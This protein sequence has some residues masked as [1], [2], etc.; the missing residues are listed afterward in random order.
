MTRFTGL[1][2]KRAGGFAGVTGVLVLAGAMLASQ[3]VAAAGNTNFEG[4]L[5]ASPPAGYTSSPGS[6]DL[7][8]GPVTVDF[9][10]TAK[11]L[12]GEA[13]TFALN[14]SADHILTYN[15]VNVA[16]GQ[17]GQ[18]GIA[19]GGPAGTTQALMPGSQAFNQSWGADATE[20]LS[21]TYSFDT[22]GYYQ[23][24]VWAPWKDGDNS[25][26]R[27]T[28]ASGFIRVL[29]C[30]TSSTPDPT[31]SPTPTGGEGAAT[32]TPAPTDGV[33]AITT[34]TPS[35]GAGSGLITLG[36]G[37]VLAG[38]GLLGVATRKRRITGDF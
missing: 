37:L 3:P 8:D 31:A 34:S 35:T 38:T 32:S 26:D 27:A 23:I 5:A 28:L 9:D 15:G 17:P 2:V 13:H 7:S 14:F 22:C 6:F 18:A 1:T 16:D 21:L 24:D 10:V 12:T 29:G 33:Q 19:F 36:A 11:N 20:T 25:R 4:I 30:A